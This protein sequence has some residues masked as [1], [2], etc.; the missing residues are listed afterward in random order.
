MD[1]HLQTTTTPYPANNVRSFSACAA[2][3]C[4]QQI[5]VVDRDG[6]PASLVADS[7]SR[8]LDMHVSVMRV[9]D[10]DE[11]LAVMGNHS[12]DLV[13]VGLEPNDLVQM[14]LLPRLH[15]LDGRVPVLVVE[16]TRS[17]MHELS[18]R[19]YGAWDVFT[20]PRRAADLRAL[21]A[22]LAQDYLEAA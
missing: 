9:E 21:I 20:L 15:D 11:A 8:L 14:T 6:G 4:T 3:V 22:R 10:H 2:V 19:R 5:L 17:W 18:A 12:V 1:R 7:A 13:L 16:G